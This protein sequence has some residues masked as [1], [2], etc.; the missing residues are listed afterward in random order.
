MGV[1]HGKDSLALAVFGFG[2]YAL[3]PDAVAPFYQEFGTFTAEYLS[4]PPGDLV[5]S[6]DPFDRSRA[7]VFC[8]RTILSEIE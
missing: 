6:E 4:P 1:E 7:Y 3:L 5:F 2:A 8:N